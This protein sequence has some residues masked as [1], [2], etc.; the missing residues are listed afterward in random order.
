MNRKSGVLFLLFASGA[1]AAVLP[2]ALREADRACTLWRGGGAENTGPERVAFGGFVRS[3]SRLHLIVSE[4]PGAESEERARWQEFAWITSPAAPSRGTESGGVPEGAKFVIA[5]D[6]NGHVPACCWSDDW[7]KAASCEETARGLWRR[8]GRD[9][10]PNPGDCPVPAWREATGLLPLLLVGAAGLWTGGGAGCALFLFLFSLAMTLPPFAGFPVGPLCVSLAAIGSVAFG[11]RLVPKQEPHR[12][13]LGR[14]RFCLTALLFVILSFLSLSHPFLSPN[15]LAVVG[16]R[17]KLWHL[18]GGFP[19]GYFET[20][21]WRFQEPAY[22]PGPAALAL[23]CFA[24]AGGSGEWLTQLAGCAATA[25]LFA[26]IASGFDGPPS[27]RLAG[28][29]WA[30]ALF[31]HPVSLKMGSQ[32]YP[33]P[34]AA[35]CV[36]AGLLRIAGNSRRD[37][38]LG[39]LLLGA[40]AWFKTEGFVFA[41]AGWCAFGSGIRRKAVFPLVVGLAPA[42]AWHV[43]VRLAGGGFNDVAPLWR[44]DCAKGFAALAKAFRLA[45]AE[46]WRYG[47]AHP[48][49]IA[50]AGWSAAARLSRKQ[51]GATACGIRN[52]PFPVLIRTLAFC[53]LCMAAFAWLLACSRAPDFD[54]HVSTSLPR[55]LWTPA[56]AII[57]LLSCERFESHRRP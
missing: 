14:L 20:D 3:G 8:N 15:G 25:L 22:P 28:A 24:F 51:N 18:A 1:L 11:V 39:W 48:V 52:D 55:L 31:L 16:G 38:F 12:D 53:F 2:S 7:V 42:I 13:T 40:S 6:G 17:A 50:A 35:L 29:L 56:V 33:E 9:S 26:L 36:A 57:I 44:P 47:F 30:L 10:A 41:I 27:R 37:D 49:A 5:P 46:P 32:L 4:T 21:V 34:L 19:D 23:S 54:W 43:G 45:F